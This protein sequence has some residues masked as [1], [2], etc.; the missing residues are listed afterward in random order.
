M[1]ELAV[2]QARGQPQIHPVPL[3]KELRE[4]GLGRAVLGLLC[5]HTVLGTLWNQGIVVLGKGL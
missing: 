3:G 5:V 1:A 2:T 4:A